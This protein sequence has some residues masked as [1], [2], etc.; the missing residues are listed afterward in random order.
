MGNSVFLISVALDVTE[1]TPSPSA[2]PAYRARTSF[3]IAWR[4][5]ARCCQSN[6]R[7]DSSAFITFALA[8]HAT[9]GR[10]GAGVR[11]PPGRR[12]RFLRPSPPLLAQI[13]PEGSSPSCM[14]FQS[15]YIAA[16]AREINRSAP[17]PG[18]SASCDA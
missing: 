15:A 1:P 4:S 14:S 12:S 6:R 18:P 10:Y 17:A 5:K 13:F 3:R 2:E 8:C 9:Y 16:E 7:G 11:S